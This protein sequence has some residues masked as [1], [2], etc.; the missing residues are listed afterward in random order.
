MRASHA[1]DPKKLTSKE[2][3]DLDT[4]LKKWRHQGVESSKF[5]ELD[6]VEIDVETCD[7]EDCKETQEFSLTMIYSR[8]VIEEQL[9]AEVEEEES[10]AS[11]EANDPDQDKVTRNSPVDGKKEGNLEEEDQQNVS[12]DSDDELTLSAADWEQKGVR[13]KPWNSK[14]SNYDPYVDSYADVLP[15]KKGDKM[16][17]ISSANIGR[18]YFK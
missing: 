4:V 8:S 7:A 11:S 16:K 2:K 15:F 5:G 9:E 6:D 1:F 12:S 13:S 17:T 3:T 18:V 14:K 10:P